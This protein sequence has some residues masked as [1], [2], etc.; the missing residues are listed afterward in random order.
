MAQQTTTTATQPNYLTAE[1]I[2]RIICNLACS[3][4]SYGRLKQHLI[5]SGR[6]DEILKE[7]ENKH[8][9]SAVDFVLYM[10]C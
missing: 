9:R 10:E 2:W 8:F 4:G 6:K 5:E 7:W 3:L 1:L